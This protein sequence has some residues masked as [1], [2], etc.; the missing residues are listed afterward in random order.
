MDQ[1]VENMIQSSN[2]IIQRL[3]TTEKCKQMD[4]N[5]KKIN[6]I[7]NKYKINKPNK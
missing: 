6:T 2:T 7:F 3:E 5:I 4:T 1:P